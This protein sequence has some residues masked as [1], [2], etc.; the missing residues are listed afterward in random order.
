MSEPQYHIL[1]VDDDETICMITNAYLTKSGYQ[2]T[3]VTNGAEA[4]AL[5]NTGDTHI[6]MVLSDVSMPVMDG[7]EL[8]TQIRQQTV[9]KDIPVIFISGLTHLEEKLKGYE[10][11]ANDYITKPF[12]NEE[13]LQKVKN[14]LQANDLKKDLSQ[15]VADSGA[16]V[17]QA[18]TYSS[19][20]GNVIEFYKNI[21]NAENYDEVSELTI[22]LSKSQSLSVTLFINTPTQTL[23][24][25]SK[26]EVSPLESN[27]IEL[28]RNKG[29]FYDF[30]ARTIINHSTFSLLIK[31]MPMDDPEQ[32]GRIKDIMGMVC[33]G[34]EAKIQ[35]LNNDVLT[36]KREAIVEV[37][38]SNIRDIAQA[39][40]KVQKES[41][42]AIEDM[43]D[44]LNE[45]IMIL[46]LAEYQ[47][48]NIRDIA[49]RCLNRS[50]DA[51][52]K[53]R[54]IHDNLEKIQDQFDLALPDNK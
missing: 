4:L 40:D 45:A 19:E 36:Q 9:N 29:R 10:V 11:G 39:F 6:D 5:L 26:G 16:V 46:G 14:I 30:G 51:F 25:S 2:V 38:K 47:E 50:N 34:L 37:I 7:Y 31:N 33:N 18:L 8:C 41:V 43:N 48:T 1:L 15:Q 35:Q 20:L 27:V 52:Y 28:A 53:G 49:E 42:S 32:Y 13:L 24:Y 54:S 23:T 17:I 3:S 22:K 12:N 21:L 44:D